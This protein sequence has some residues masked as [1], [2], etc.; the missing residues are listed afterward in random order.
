MFSS[1]HDLAFTR[2]FLD[3]IKTYAE[4]IGIKNTSDILV[5]ALAKIVDENLNVKIKFLEN[6]LPFIDF[7][8]SNGDEGINIL[9]N[10]MINILQELY[11]QKKEDYNE[12]MKKLLFKNFVKIAKNILPY[13]TNQ[14]ILYII[15]GF[16]NEDNYRT[17]LKKNK[18]ENEKNLKIDEHK[19]LCIRY[20]RNLAEGFGKEITERY[21]LPQLTSFTVEKNDDI[22]K[23]LLITLPIISEIVAVEFISSKVYDILKR[24]GNDLNPN[25]R[26]VCVIAIAK[27]IKIFKNKCQE[28][29]NLK[30]DDKKFSAKNFVAL[31]EKLSKDKDNNVR[32]KIIEKIGEIIAPLDP[33]E[34]SLQ[35]FEFYKN[36][37]KK[38]NELKKSQNP[39]GATFQELGNPLLNK[40]KISGL[41]SGNYSYLNDEDSADYNEVNNMEND[42]NKQLTQKEISYYLAYNF[43]AIFFQL[44]YTVMEI[45]IGM[46]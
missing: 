3:N 5:P 6:L 38:H 32:Y 46:I 37:C 9:K 12:Q 41:G 13:D 31:I 15:I 24:I 19:I 7:L 25:L 16:G 35:L 34:L 40:I 45:N 33:D 36:F 18:Q 11:S 8:C 20:I 30:K 44:F 10:N 17:H 26:K 29:K 2:K 39:L 27:I 43:P 1:S 23:E 42:Y 14:S 28:I 22:K 21:L 4:I